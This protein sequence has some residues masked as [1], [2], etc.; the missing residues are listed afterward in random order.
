MSHVIDKKIFIAELEPLRKSL[1]Y[2]DTMP[3][4]VG[5]SIFI[6]QP[7]FSDYDMISNISKYDIVMFKNVFD[8]LKKL[9]DVFL[10][11]IKIQYLNDTKIR[12]T[13]YDDFEIKDFDN[14]DYIKIDLVVNIK[15]TLR[16]LSCIYTTN[17]KKTSIVDLKLDIKQLMKEGNYFKAL[18]R[19]YTIFRVQQNYKCMVLLNESLFNNMYGELYVV[20][21]ILQAVVLLHDRYPNEKRV[22]Q[23]ITKQ[24]KRINSNINLSNIKIY[25]NN[26]NK[27]INI[28]AYSIYES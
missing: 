10:I 6:N 26:I 1:T 13:K 9:K 14:I 4:L 12:F 25:I 28:Y 19:Q 11:E 7:N 23:L 2:N 18:K 16:E 21:S 22:E 15:A 3:I 17:N 5:S 8:K 20:L 27:K 24:L